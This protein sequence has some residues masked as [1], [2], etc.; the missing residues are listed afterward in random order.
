MKKQAIIWWG[1]FNFQ[2]NK[3][4]FWEIG[5][6]LLGIERQPQEWRIASN[7]SDDLEQNNIQVGVEKSPPFPNDLLEFKR[8]LF[9]Q[10]SS[11]ITLTPILADR[12]QV[13]HADTA[14]YL[15]P[16]QEATI[17]VSSP[18]WVRIET[19]NPKNTLLE[20]PVV[21]QSDTWHGPNTLEGD[22][23]YASRTFCRTDLESLPV[24]SHRVITPV[25][26]YNH[27]KSPLLI[28]Q[29]SLPLPYLSIYVDANGGLWTEELVIK[30]EINYKHTVKQGKGAPH[31]AKD[32]NLIS[33]PRLS[34]KG[35]NF[36]SM[37]YSLL[38]E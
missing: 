26:I 28:E 11:T 8:F 33:A 17:Y 6:L 5:A 18:V 22:L 31:I 4:R 32:A 23:C 30:N 20:I 27:S 13:S 9:H 19:G 24:R 25:I 1:T 7:S 12:A 34:L 36:I 21:R 38:S 35:M 15:P 2:E 10:T 3:P 14:F 37:F 29:L 16:N